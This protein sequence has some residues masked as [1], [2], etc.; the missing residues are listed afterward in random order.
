MLNNNKL[1]WVVAAEA[2][3]HHLLKLQFNDGSIKL[4]DC[5]PLIAELPAFKALGNEEVFRKIELDGWTVTWLNGTIDLAPE[6]LYENS[7]PAYDT[8]EVAPP[9]V[10]E[11]QTPYKPSK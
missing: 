10:A 6:Y 1:V 2:L 8:S 5:K 11:A 7:V 3:E 4:F 9:I